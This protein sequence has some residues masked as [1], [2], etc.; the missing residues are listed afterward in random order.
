M[1]Q[2]RRC[3]GTE[4]IDQVK[5]KKERKSS[6]ECVQTTQFPKYIVLLLSL[7]LGSGVL[8]NA[9]SVI[10]WGLWYQPI[11]VSREFNLVKSLIGIQSC[12]R[13]PG[14]QA[15]FHAV[16]FSTSLQSLWLPIGS[17]LGQGKKKS[18]SF[19]FLS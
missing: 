4:N 11:L 12:P 14:P 5:G 13:S 7:L 6:E 8:G 15:S 16:C 9:E 17:G 10:L 3:S 2:A 19:V 1:C 18:S